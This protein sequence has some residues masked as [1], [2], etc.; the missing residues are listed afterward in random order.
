MTKIPAEHNFKH[1]IWNYFEAGHGKSVADA[2]GS[3]VKNNADK[4][5]CRGSDVSFV[6]Q[7]SDKIKTKMYVITDKDTYMIQEMEKKIP[8]VMKPV[9]QCMKIHQIV[10]EHE[11]RKM[12]LRQISCTC[13]SSHLDTCE[14]CQLQG[15]SAIYLECN[16]ETKA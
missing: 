7:L 11:E 4:I 16:M 1:V 14:K 12:I 10:Y 9:P 6:E 15:V 13:C 8:K 2:I 5:V 3:V